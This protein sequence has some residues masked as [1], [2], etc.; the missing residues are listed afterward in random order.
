MPQSVSPEGLVHDAR[1][2]NT[3]DSG[4]QRGGGRSGAAVV[5]G[6]G[7]SRKQPGVRNLVDGDDVIAQAGESGP[8]ALHYCPDSGYTYRGA[9]GLREL[10]SLGGGGAPETDEDG[11]GLVVEKFCQFFWEPVASTS[12]CI[13]VNSEMSVCRPTVL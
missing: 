2:G 5:H 6:G 8:P 3:G 13:G 7:H 9:D 1:D 11:S 12:K 4:P 10:V